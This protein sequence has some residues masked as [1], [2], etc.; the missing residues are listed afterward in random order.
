MK[1]TKLETFIVDVP[2]PGYGG[3]RWFFVKLTTDEGVYG[4]GETAT[5]TVYYPLQQSYKTLLEEIFE[6][7]L[8]NENPLDRERLSKKVY[9]IAYGAAHRVLHHGA[10]KRD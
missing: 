6:A 5:L 1:L 7:F 10:G 4:W 9:T 3:N 2:P 8:K